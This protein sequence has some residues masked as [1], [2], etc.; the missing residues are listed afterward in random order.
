M[1]AATP[2]DEDV[3]ALVSRLVGEEA[4]TGATLSRPRR[5]DPSRPARVTVAPIIVGGEPS[6]LPVFAPK[7]KPVI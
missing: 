2:P 5:S 4:L 7:Q 6:E 1:S 3:A